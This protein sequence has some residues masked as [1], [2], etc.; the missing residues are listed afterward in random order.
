MAVRRRV[1]EELRGFD[2]LLGL[3][4][5]FRAAEETDFAIRAL[6]AGYFVLEDPA[7]EVTHTG[8]RTWD[9]LPA[10]IER[11]WFGTG[12]ALAKL[13]KRVPSSATVIGARLAWNWAFQPSGVV[14][15]LG[16]GAHRRLRLHAFALGMSAGLR[17]PIDPT[18][19][20]F[21]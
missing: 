1:C 12:A 16:G 10:L 5:A 19:G 11:N 8:F 4:A 13:V 2:P 14:A 9:E 3:G 18:T 15:T 17:R 7:I 20:H 21:V 6:Q